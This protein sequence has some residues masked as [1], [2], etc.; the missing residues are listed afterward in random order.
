[1]TSHMA[2]AVP[3]Q[4]PM[5]RKLGA[6]LQNMEL[7]KQEVAAIKGNTTNGQQRHQQRDAK[8]LQ[9]NCCGTNDCVRG[10]YNI[11]NCWNKKRGRKEDATI[12]SMMGGSRETCFW[13]NP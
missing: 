9:H 4:Q 8:A 10:S 5:D 6:L 3:S 2:N 12:K 7:L 1:M 13:L 11:R